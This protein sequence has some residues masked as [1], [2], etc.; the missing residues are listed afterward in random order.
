MKSASEA[1][2]EHWRSPIYT[3]FK[4]DV[5]FQVHDGRPS[6]F[7]PCAA[8]KCKVRA[9]GVRRYQD[10]TDKSSTANLKH[11]ALRCFGADAVNA[12][13]A[14]KEH[15]NRSSGIF[16]FFARKGKQPVKY[17]H[18]VHTNPE[19]RYVFLY[20]ILIHPCRPLTINCS[21]HLVKWLTENNRPINVINDRELRDLLTAGRPS[22]QLPTNCTISRDIQASFDKCRERIAKLLR[23]HPGRLHFATDAWTSPNHRAFIAWTVH[24]EYEGEMLAFLLDIVELPEVCQIIT[25]IYNY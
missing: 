24:L 11:H 21:A 1:L 2:Q 7:F 10:S 25:R 9:G 5:V 3:F 13:I 16:K 14:G 6:H 8:P 18:R 22:V 20:Y 17:S 12:A 23:E 4:S 15:A 19:V